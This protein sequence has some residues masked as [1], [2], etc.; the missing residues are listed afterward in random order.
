MSLLEHYHIQHLR[1]KSLALLEDIAHWNLVTQARLLEDALRRLDAKAGY[2]PTQPRV[3][4]G[5][6][7]GG[8]WVAVYGEGEGTRNPQELREYEYIIYDEEGNEHVVYDP[9]IEPIYPIEEGAALI[10]GVTA[11]LS[12][13]RVGVGAL[14]GEREV[15]RWSLGKH[16]SALKWANRMKKRGWTNQQID[17]VLANGKQFPAPNLVNP[18]NN[19]TRYVD[20][21]TGRFVVRDD[22]SGEI[23]QISGDG[24]NPLIK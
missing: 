6:P 23:L 21:Q 20:T 10:G 15:I 19:A 1:Q 2:K 13:L 22:V 11:L 14:I 24:Y 3:P 7:D 17:D 18:A 8:Q 12:G 9:P 16:K 5:N 4:A